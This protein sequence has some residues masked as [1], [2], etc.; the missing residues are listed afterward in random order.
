MS[1]GCLN[2]LAKGLHT[3][4]LMPFPN[5]R[6]CELLSKPLDLHSLAIL[7]HGLLKGMRAMLTKM[8]MALVVARQIQ[9][10]FL[11]VFRQVDRGCLALPWN[12]SHP[13]TLLLSSTRRGVVLGPLLGRRDR[14]VFVFLPA[15]GDIGGERVIWV[16]G[17]E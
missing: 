2:S 5:V 16:G 6:T 12:S 11:N 7:Y 3:P 8:S 10:W 17:S 14:V 13:S 15:L 9:N 4:D 1:L